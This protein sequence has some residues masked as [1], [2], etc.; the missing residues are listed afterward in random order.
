MT[1][2]M[3]LVGCEKRQALAPVASPAATAPARRP[4]ESTVAVM[5]LPSGDG[6]RGESRVQI[7]MDAGPNAVDSEVLNKFAAYVNAEIAILQ[8]DALV[9]VA[10]QQPQWQEVKPGAPD[11]ASILDFRDH[12]D[13][14]LVSTG[15]GYISVAFTAAGPNAEREVKAAVQSVYAAWMIARRRPQPGIAERRAYW[16]KEV[17]QLAARLD[18]LQAKVSRD[19]NAGD[20]TAEI[21]KTKARLEEAS[22]AKRE[23]DARPID[24]LAIR[25]LNTNEFSTPSN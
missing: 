13:V 8:S 10:M 22:Q 7:S 4:A 18:A 20:G 23:W 3:A 1:A 5:R 16:Q 6:F 21:A 11:V 12:L 17:E 25:L 24:P 2:L 14:K 15:R 9:R 19:S